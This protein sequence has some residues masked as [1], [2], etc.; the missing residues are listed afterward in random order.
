M[1]W[2]LPRDPRLLVYD[3]VGDQQRV[4]AGHRPDLLSAIPGALARA[5]ATNSRRWFSAIEPGI[6]VPACTERTT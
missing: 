3:V 1:R 4:E 5:S 2:T 6:S